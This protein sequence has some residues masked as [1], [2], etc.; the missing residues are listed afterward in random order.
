MKKNEKLPVLKIGITRLA[1]LKMMTLTSLPLISCSFEESNQQKRPNVIII[2][3]DDQGYG[4]LA[5]HGNPYLNTPNMDNLYKESVRLT[6]YHVDPSSSPTRAALLTGS[7]ASRV[8]VWHTARGRHLLFENMTT[9]AELFL[10]NGYE[11]AI[12]GKW[13]LGDTYPFRPMD[14]G[15]KESVFHGAGRVG[16]DADYWGNDYY[17]DTYM[18]N[19]VYKQYDGYCNTVWFD[20]ATSYMRE[21][22]DKPFF[23]Y[24]PT[25]LPHY[26]LIVDEEYIKHRD[27]LSEKVASFYGMLNKL[28]EDLG[29]LLIEIKGMGLEE[30]TILMFKG[31]NGPGPW[32]GGTVID[33]ETGSLLEG[34]SAGM[35]GG[36]IYGYENAHRVHCFLRWPGGGIEGGRDIDALSAHIDIVPTLIDLC[37]LDVPADF[38]YDGQN[39]SPL[40]TGELENWPDERTHFIHNQRVENAVKDKDYTV[41]TDQWRLVKREKDELYRIKTDPGQ[42]EDVAAKYPGVVKELYSRYE[43]W[44][45]KISDAFDKYAKI[46]IGTENENP[47]RFF[48]H[49][50]FW[51]G[52]E[53]IWPVNVARNGKYKVGLK[54]WPEE[55]GKRIVENR[56]G[57][58][59][60]P[61][62]TA[63]LIVGNID[64]TGAVTLEMTSKTFFVNLKAGTT[65]F[66][67]YFQMNNGQKVPTMR[68]NVEYVGG[69]SEED[70][71][72][73]IPSEPSH[74][75]RN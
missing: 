60:Q 48:A 73:Y 30:N 66:Q 64:L 12:F 26:P 72:D 21:N 71:E 67:T 28:D 11:T 10:D 13:H 65:C 57:D 1:T 23:I 15:F 34:Y 24:L 61:V 5:C 14:R 33:F 38:Q 9:I 3:T 36:K 49:D 18:H 27:Q 7:Y 54:R 39:L 74:L 37:N 56:E 53:R 25:N 51:R 52:G 69:V 8:G 75:L 29:L 35:R 55:S 20:E 6:N 4:D 45:D 41:L 32:F 17:D 2:M 16:S 43:T 46:Q 50:A 19:G 40:L 22:K 42:R 59:D 31:D 58:I 68:L 63:N 62:E 44:W 47:V 70:I